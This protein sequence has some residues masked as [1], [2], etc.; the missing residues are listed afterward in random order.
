[1]Q[2]RR[3][4]V[5]LNLDYAGLGAGIWPTLDDLPPLP[6][7]ETIFEPRLSADQ[8]DASYTY[9]QRAVERARGWR[10]P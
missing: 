6:G 1:M 2:I 3:E 7:D 9:W 8:R 10:R 4:E 5:I